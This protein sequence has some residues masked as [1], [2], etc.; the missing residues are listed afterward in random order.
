L[1]EEFVDPRFYPGLHGSQADAAGDGVNHLSRLKDE[2]AQSAPARPGAKADGRV[3]EA[4][5]APGVN[6]R[7]KSPRIRCSGG[8]GVRINGSEARTWGKLSDISLHECYLEMYNTFPVGTK[9]DLVLKSCDFQIHCAG[10]VRASYPALGMGI[11]FEE[12]DLGQQNHLKQLLA[13]LIGRR[14]PSTGASGPENHAKEAY[15]MKEV[16]RSADPRALVDKVMEYFQKDH[17]LPRDQ[18]Y[19]IARRVRRS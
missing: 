2:P 11:R 9:L 4:T 6:E 19:E 13:F 16:L 15:L 10:R 17:L 7:R 14:S 1:S 3:A 18:F 12:I 8:V 5:P